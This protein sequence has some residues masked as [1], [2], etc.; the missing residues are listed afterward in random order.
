MSPSLFD[1]ALFGV[2]LD[3]RALVQRVKRAAVVI[4]GD[5]RREIGPGVLVFLGVREGDDPAQCQKLAAKCAGLRIFDD[6]D[7]KLNLSAVDLGYAALVVSQFTLYGDARKGKRPSFTAAA[8]PPL[9]VDC[10]EEFV[11]CMRQQGLKDVQ[12][13]E[14]G[15]EMQ[16]ELVNDGPVTIWLDTDD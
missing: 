13:G 2:A 11:R 7:G 16:V 8:K 9:S 14:F 15:A 1:Y 4:E 10:Y 12:T 6:G 5:E 3:M